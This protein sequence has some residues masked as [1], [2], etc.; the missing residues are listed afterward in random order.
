ME[1]ISVEFARGYEPDWL[2]EMVDEFTEDPYC[3]LVMLGADD[4]GVVFTTMWASEVAG[5][6]ADAL[7]KL[8]PVVAVRRLVLSVPVAEES[9]L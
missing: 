9:G 1:S 8:D 5:E 2:Q 4:E 7:R 6:V 3:H